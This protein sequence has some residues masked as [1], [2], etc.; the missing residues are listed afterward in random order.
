MKIGDKAINDFKAVAWRNNNLC[1]GNEPAYII[2]I[3]P[4]A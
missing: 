1:F 2:L 3:K 4:V